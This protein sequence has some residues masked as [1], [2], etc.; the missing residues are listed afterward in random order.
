[1]CL[2]LSLN[3][4]SSET[5]STEAAEHCSPAHRQQRHINRRN[6]DSVTSVRQATVSRANADKHTV[7]FNVQTASQRKLD[8]WYLPVELSMLDEWLDFD[9]FDSYFKRSKN[10]EQMLWTRCDE[11]WRH[12][13]T[14][15]TSQP[16]CQFVFTN[17]WWDQNPVRSYGKLLSGTWSE[18]PPR[19]PYEWLLPVEQLTSGLAR[20]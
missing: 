3:R 15:Q 12:G 4:A 5:A 11:R 16:P 14:A 19:S 6:T 20:R 9:F 7:E 1:M 2:S 17:V 10:R 8:E 18:K 13:K